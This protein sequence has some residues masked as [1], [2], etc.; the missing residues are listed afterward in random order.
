MDFR[1]GVNRSSATL[2]FV[3]F[4][5]VERIS[6]K[7]ERIPTEVERI[8]HKVEHIQIQLERISK[9]WKL[10]H[11][12]PSAEKQSSFVKFSVQNLTERLQKAENDKSLHPYTDRCKLLFLS[13][14]RIH[15][16]AHIVRK[17]NRF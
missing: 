11:E 8:P 5:G 10:Q 7:V 17:R 6:S 16:T 4:K 15:Q 2:N 12:N 1:K 3:C 13:S 14:D 9:S